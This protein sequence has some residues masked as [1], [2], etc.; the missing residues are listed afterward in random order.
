MR[1]CGRTI[2]R[3]SVLAAKEA[4]ALSTSEE[5]WTGPGRFYPQTK[6]SLLS[7]MPERLMD[8]SLRMEDDQGPVN[9]RCGFFQDREPFAPHRGLEASEACNVASRA[10][11]ACN[12]TAANG[13]ADRHKYRRYFVGHDDIV[14]LLNTNL[15]EEKAAD[16]KLSTVALR[17]GVNRKAAS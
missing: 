4:K 16:R 3:P 7:G 14:R 1:A 12:K 5:L 11:E 10:R 6:S 8:G 17:K 13:I 9:V 2:I 15:N